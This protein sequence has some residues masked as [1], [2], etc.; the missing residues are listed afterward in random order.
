MAYA[1]L[2]VI[3][4]VYETLSG[5][6]TLMTLV[7]N[8][9]SDYIADGTPYPYIRIGSLDSNDR[10]SDTTDGWLHAITVHVWHQTQSRKAALEIQ[11]RIDT[12]LHN[13]AFSFGSFTNLTMRRDFSTVLEEP[14]TV[15]YHGIQRFL[16]MSGT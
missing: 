6:A 11:A 8:R 3:K 12:L 1:P 2:E 7:G 14:D 16:T 10:G 5:D 4:K 15:T 13:A 9:I